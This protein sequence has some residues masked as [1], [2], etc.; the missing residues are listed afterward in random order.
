M[1]KTSFPKKYQD[2]I[3]EIENHKL[4]TGCLMSNN[5]Y[6]RDEFTVHIDDGHEISGCYYKEIMQ[7][8]KDYINNLYYSDKETL[9]D[10]QTKE[11]NDFDFER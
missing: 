1:E 11:D 4:F 2:H 8:V 9:Q 6:T 7:E 10:E 5:R 3:T